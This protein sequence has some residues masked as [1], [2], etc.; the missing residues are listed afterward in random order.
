MK[1][2]KTVTEKSCFL[3]FFNIKLF[4]NKILMPVL[5]FYIVNS[6]KFFIQWAFYD[7][8]TQ[9]ENVDE[10]KCK[11]LNSMILEKVQLIF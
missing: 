4:K 2:G 7:F 6:H 3:I 10:P 1:T 11:H 8:C 5:E 9:K